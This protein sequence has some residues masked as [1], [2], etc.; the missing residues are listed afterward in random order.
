MPVRSL[1]LAGAEESPLTDI[2]AYREVGGY[3]SL[4]KARGLEPSAVLE[5]I[6]AA[7]IRG[8]GGAGFPMGKK[9]SFLAKD[10]GR[11]V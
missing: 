1:V 9:A 6:L 11:P 10:P 8:R 7:N 2:S 5:E 3:Q 4:G